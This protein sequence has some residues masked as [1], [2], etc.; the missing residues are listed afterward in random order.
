MKRY[1]ATPQRAISPI[2]IAVLLLVG[3]MLSTTVVLGA[4]EI[5]R[6]TGRIVD[7]AGIVSRAK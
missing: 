6:L 5:P 2:V 3:A 4:Q 1:P 7:N